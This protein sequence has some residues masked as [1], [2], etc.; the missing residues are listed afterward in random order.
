MDD[1]NIT[2][3]L[4]EYQHELEIEA[5]ILIEQLSSFEIQ[6]VNALFY[7]SLRTS[8]EEL[9][10]E[11][12]A[13]AAQVEAALD[14]LSPLELF[15]LN[16]GSISINKETRKRLEPL[17]ERLESDFSP[18][19]Q[20]LVDK[21]SYVP[22]NLLPKWYALP[23]TS[24]QIT[25]SIIDKY[26]STPSKYTQQLTQL[27][28]NNAHAQQMCDILYRSPQLRV[29]LRDVAEALSLSLRE[30]HALILELE[31][32]FACCLTY[33]M[34]NETLKPIVVPPTEWT[35][36]LATQEETI[37]PLIREDHVKR[38]HRHDFGFVNDM[39][40]LLRSLLIEV[41]T[42]D[43]ERFP[44]N[45]AILDRFT[46][47]IPTELATIHFQQLVAALDV[48][49]LANVKKSALTLTPEGN[50]WLSLTQEEQAMLLY[51]CHLK[52]YHHNS[53]IFSDRDVRKVEKALSALSPNSWIPF[54]TFC[55]STI[56]AIGTTTPVTLRCVG[57][58]WHYELPTYSDQERTFIQEV[59]TS[60]LYQCGMIATGWYNGQ[61]HFKVTPFG[62]HSLAHE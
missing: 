32:H 48:L 54:E 6:L 39:G 50:S 57:R 58:R 3:N 22:I 25:Q 12:N 5:R 29:P 4:S 42:L 26:L 7:S 40:K 45:H 47:S 14:A 28:N 51:F 20:Y 11:L 23:H 41:I 61:L 19:I 37:S 56:G 46:T 44:D 1:S 13:D 10:G 52:C 38:M 59:L 2:I 24:D 49:N 18:T 30:C 53:G 27:K 17:I 55:N 31:F 9:Q 21:L 34:V 8:V 36:Y 33:E 15:H 16:N 35:C 43:K 62:Q 60:H